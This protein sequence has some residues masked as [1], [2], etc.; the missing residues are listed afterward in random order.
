MIEAGKIEGSE[1]VETVAE[2]VKVAFWWGKLSLALGCSTGY[3]EGYRQTHLS[4][5]PVLLL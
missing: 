3:D 1:P 5:T 4:I 2:R